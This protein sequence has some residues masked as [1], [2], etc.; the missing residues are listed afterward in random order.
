MG[1]AVTVIYCQNKLNIG[2]RLKPLL[3]N[4]GVEISDII[5]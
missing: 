1:K 3:P 4:D 2:R 5:K